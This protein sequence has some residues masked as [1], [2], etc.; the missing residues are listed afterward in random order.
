MV[1]R[2][3][4]RKLL[5]DLW[6]IKGQVI[7]ISLVIAAAVAVYVMYLGAFESLRLTQTAYYSR[8][9]FAD[10]FAGLKRGPL[11]LEEQIREIP[12]VAQVA[13]RV[14][15]AVTLDVAGM[16]E[17]A[18]GRL[19][20]IP[21]ERQPMLNDIFIR[22]GRYIDPERSNE[23]LINEGF[24]LAHGLEPGDTLSAVINGRRRRLEIAGIAL[25]PEYL[26][27]IRPGD[28]VPDDKRYGILWMNRDELAAAFNM[29]GGFND[30]ALGLM[31]GASEKDVI[32]SLDRLLDRYGG[33]G[34]IPRSLQLSHW[35]LNNELN[36]LQ[37]FGVIIPLIFLSVAGF[38]LNVVLSRIVSVQREQIAAL[39]A[40][41]Y[42]NLEVGIHYYQ[43]GILVALLGTAIGLSAGA[44]LASSLV[45]IY[46]DFFRFPLLEFQ[47]A[48]RILATAMLI[49]LVTALLGTRGAVRRAVKLPPAEAMRPQAPA[50][51]RVSLIERIGL[52]AWLSPTTRMIVRNI[53]RR[54][55]RSA[56]S[57]IGIAFGAAMVIVGMFF[58]DAMTYAMDIQFHVAQRQ[59]LTV[60]FVEP[61]SSRAFY[62]MGSVDGVMTV[63]PLRSVPV[64]LQ[65]G[66]RSRQTA[67]TGLI[68]GAGLNRVIDSRLR[69]LAIPPDG[70]V[71]STKMAEILGAKAGDTLQIDVL[72]GARP[73]REAVVAAV[74]E[75]FMGAS[76]YMDLDSLH[77]LM[78]EDRVLSGAYLQVDESMLD[79][80][81]SRL[82]GIP[83]V[84]GVALKKAVIQS[85]KKTI[86]QN[87]SVMIFF[88]QIFSNIIA[89]GV[90]YNAVRI[91]LSERGWELAS[92]RV[93][94]FTR[95]EISRILLGE[96]AVL[97]GIAIPLGLAIGY[98]L[99]AFTVATVGDTELYRIPLVVA[100]STFAAAAATVLA[101]AFVSGLVVRRRLNRLNLVA[102]LKTRE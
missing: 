98:G 36:Q 80:I 35:Y 1:M 53:S 79:Q 97:V 13:L 25:S 78:R 45:R 92:L 34:A 58:L 41:G 26:Y 87:M 70:I 76:A 90:I 14:S 88:N 42:T 28:I 96:F 95:G 84:A 12:G 5:R 100:E 6:Y 50:H 33:L 56:L 46:N 21:P 85:F 82:K 7:A 32:S 24:A 72:E 54:P 86:Q 48:P 37:S 99:A 73:H 81:Y 18:M 8:Y 11:S 61:A 23:V 3:L 52:G 22:R 74:A 40:L 10:V 101:A 49:S 15:A 19:V 17:P 27:T 59:D 66:P 93:M 102:V 47:V 2:A 62:E 31:P 38:L 20:S 44:W 65:F 68:E 30:I 71:L 43:W 64:R 91:S 69:P 55:L 57:T 77:R 60:S 16:S 75:E 94:G 67:I 63:E 39:K 51:F 29:S 4:H 83:V 9:R 89:F